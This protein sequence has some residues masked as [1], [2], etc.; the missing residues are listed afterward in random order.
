MYYSRLNYLLFE[1]DT[2]KPKIKTRALPLVL[3]LL[4]LG[5]LA[6]CQILTPAIQENAQNEEHKP[7]NFVV[8]VV[9][10]LGFMD[11][12]PNNPE[13]FYETPNLNQLAADGV[14]FSNSYAANPVCSPSRYALMT[15]INPARINATDWFHAA[16]TKRLQGR[17]RAARSIEMMPLEESTIAEALPESYKTAFVGKWHLGE[18]ETLWP[19]HQG[20]DTNIA[21]WANGSPKGGYFSPYQN[22]RLADGDPN[23][24]LT[25]RLTNEAIAQIEHFKDD[26]FMVYLSYYSVHVP[27]QAPQQTIDKYIDKAKNIKPGP[28]FSTEEQVL[29]QAKRSR[30]VRIVQD[31]P[32]YAAMVEH[33]DN[34]VGR[35]IAKLESSGLADNTIIILTSDNGGLSTSEGLPT[36]NLPLRGG[37]GWIYEGGIRVPMIIK[38]PGHSQT[39]VTLNTPVIGMDIPTT[40]LDIAN[41][42][43]T[44]QPLDG[45][46]LKALLTGEEASIERPLFWHYPHYS[47]QGG[48]PAAAV[49]LGKYKLIQRLE[50]GRV[51]LYDLDADPGELTDLS[52]ILPAKTEQLQNLLMNW[53]QQVDA[54]FLQ[55]VVDLDIPWSAAVTK[56][57]QASPH[58]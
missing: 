23:E 9:D 11:I 8:I 27:L 57:K 25:H 15:G 4:T 48:M 13:T 46:S 34:N 54:Q 10:D 52:D 31:H 33:M 37:K 24:Y 19:E 3:G 14:T 35:I 2:M 1:F 50:D 32:T 43:N 51:H 21:G 30:Q 22:P 55:P 56:G 53:Y 36:S 26:N 42:P 44:R 39:G 40:I 47:N 49:R 29:P 6:S 12:E 7:W 5:Y 17:Y 38:W 58:F 16:N 45:H 20:F 41:S 18:D 28:R